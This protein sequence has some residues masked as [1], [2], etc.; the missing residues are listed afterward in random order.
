MFDLYRLDTFDLHGPVSALFAV[1]HK[2]VQWVKSK[3]PLLVRILIHLVEEQK[4]L[5]SK[6]Q[7]L[8]KSLL[9]ME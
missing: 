5:H 2:T 4:L 9:G 3:I 1:G 6:N 7:K 8:N